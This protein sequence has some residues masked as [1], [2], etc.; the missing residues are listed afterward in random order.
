[1]ADSPAL[2]PKKPGMLK[3]VAVM[4][5]DTNHNGVGYET[6]LRSI[7]AAKKNWQLIFVRASK[8]FTTEL[9]ED[10][11]LFMASRTGIPDPIDFFPDPISDF[12]QE[13][14]VFWDDTN[15]KAVVDNIRDRG[16]GFLSLH[17]T[18]YSRRQEILDV[19]GVEPVMH[20]RIQP[21]WAHSLNQGHPITEGIDEFKINLD[22]QFGA[23]IKSEYTTTLFET[24][25]IHDKRELVG[26]WCRE[27]GKGKVVAL[28]P[29]HTYDP[30]RVPE[31]REILWRAA[32]W[33]V[34]EDIPQFG[35]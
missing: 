22:E 8:A 21:L 1:M 2:F 7:F 12:A 20:R 13:G 10:A 15:T 6:A 28:L 23:L 24:T 11:D 31:Y 19:L 32:H 25:G 33:A 3:V 18:L 17:C 30:Y 26:G 4:A 29:G 27:H 16:M 35:G 9:I 5:H 14:A 34:G